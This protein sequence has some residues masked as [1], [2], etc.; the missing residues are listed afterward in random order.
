[1]SVLTLILILGIGILIGIRIMNVVTKQ[2]CIGMLKIYPP[3]PADIGDK[4]YLFLELF[5]DTD[6]FK[7]RQY[8]MLKIQ[9]NIISHK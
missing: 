7:N 6:S 2:D 4:P 9:N 1:M 3:E 5:N 8:I